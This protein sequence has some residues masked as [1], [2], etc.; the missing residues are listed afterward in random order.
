MVVTI[1][2]VAASSYAIGRFSA[3]E[4]RVTT[5]T[6]STVTATQ[7]IT[8]PTTITKTE[9]KT[10]T[11]T[12]TVVREPPNTIPAPA[13]SSAI[14]GA[15]L[16][17]NGSVFLTISIDKPAYSQ[18]ESMHIKSTVTN[19]SPY[20]V[21]LDFDVNAIWIYNSSGKK[22]WTYPERIFFIGLGP[23]IDNLWIDLGPYC[24]AGLASLWKYR[25]DWPDVPKEPCKY[26]IDDATV[27]WNMTGLHTVTTR[28]PGHTSTRI[29]YDDHYLPEGEY[30]LVWKPTLRLG[31]QWEWGGQQETLSETI[32]FTITK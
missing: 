25:S 14:M 31:S 28:Y 26:S 24:S 23:G 3:L 17:L 13:N 1:V 16:A 22:V 4:E 21:S 32:P 29:V 30:T 20:N 5:T 2:L 7:I 15:R 11:F 8:S 9:M 19:L 18:G 10:T 12:T 27:N 6:T